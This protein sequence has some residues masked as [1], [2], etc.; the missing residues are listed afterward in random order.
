MN[1][2][3][4]R[5]DSREKK[6]DRRRKGKWSVKA[7]DAALRLDPSGFARGSRDH[8]EYFLETSARYGIKIASCT[9]AARVIDK[10]ANYLITAS[11]E[12]SSL[13]IIGSIGLF[14]GR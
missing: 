13:I 8:L 4:D 9:I 6:K 12:S 3:Y 7:G 10:R 14:R 1:D 11:R 5:K 2:D